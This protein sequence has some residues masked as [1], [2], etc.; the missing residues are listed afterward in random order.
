M[1]S[2]SRDCAAHSVFIKFVFV[3]SNGAVNLSVQRFGS[4]GYLRRFK[5]TVVR[6]INY[7]KQPQQLKV[8]KNGLLV[9]S[10]R[11]KPLNEDED[12]DDAF[13]DYNQESGNRT[14]F[15]V[16]MLFTVRAVES[17]SLSCMDGEFVSKLLHKRKSILVKKVSNSS[18]TPFKVKLVDLIYTQECQDSLCIT[19]VAFQTC[20]LKFAGY[21]EPTSLC[22]HQP[23]L[24]LNKCT[25][26]PTHDWI[27]EN[28]VSTTTTPTITTTTSLP[29]ST[30]TLETEDSDTGFQ[31]VNSLSDSQLKQYGQSC[32][33][34]YNPCQNN[35]I[36][37]QVKVQSTHHHQRGAKK[38]KLK[39]HCFCPNG[40]KGRFCEEDIDEC[41]ENEQLLVNQQLSS[42]IKLITAKSERQRLYEGPCVSHAECVNTIGS[43]VCNCSSLDATA[44]Y[45]TQ[46]PQFQHLSSEANKRLG[47]YKYSN[48]HYTIKNDDDD[49]EKNNDEDE[50]GA[51]EDEIEII[52]DTEETSHVK[53]TAR[54]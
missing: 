47:H 28:P 48:Y 12:E 21:N 44:C 20:K 25:L 43:Y 30:T 9:F 37:K 22:E 7:Q 23:R 53:G 2:V 6:L 45:N 36:C 5:D 49:D 39:I 3:A 13:E 1:E 33:K 15:T 46:S 40:F 32:R 4:L 51:A 35:A 10:I 17:T 34:P 26:L 29:S 8:P 31:R 18:S 19:N 38:I 54:Y 41:S 42:K 11:V 24:N 52:D 14:R 16:E 50:N 27:C